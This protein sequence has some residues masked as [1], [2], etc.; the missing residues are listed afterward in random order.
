[1]TSVPGGD[2]AAQVQA[3]VDLVYQPT[4]TPEQLTAGQYGALI[5]NPSLAQITVAI[6]GLQ[7]TLAGNPAGGVIG[8]DQVLDHVRET[9]PKIPTIQKG[10]EDIGNRMVQVETTLT[11]ILT[12]ADEQLKQLQTQAEVIKQVTEA[13]LTRGQAQAEEIKKGD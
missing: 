4:Q 10:V 9:A 3:L 8:Y 13:E 5:D 2:L 7:N 1:M 6:K 12:E 11:P